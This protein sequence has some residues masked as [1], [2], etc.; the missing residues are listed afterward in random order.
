MGLINHLWQSTVFGL[1]AGVLTLALRKNRAQVRYGLWL[2][3]SVKFLI[4]F[5][6]LMSLGSLAPRPAVVTRIAPPAVAVAI[7]QLAEPLPET[8]SPVA[9]RS[10]VPWI[11]IAWACG[12]ADVVM[13]RLRGWARVRTAVRAS[14]PVKLSAAVEVRSAPGLLEPGVVGVFQP[15]LL[16]PK[17]IAEKLTLAQFEA[18]LTHELGHVRRRDNLTS[19]IHMLVRDPNAPGPRQP[20]EPTGRPSIFTA[21]QEQLGL[22][23]ESGKGSREVLV[24]DHVERPSEN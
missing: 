9:P 7:V 15:I 5:A 22:K 17:G 24:I 11:A 10:Q 13:M 4:P 20:S 12:F 21:L 1:A 14:T 6:F 2:A 18:V 19:A 3:A 8:S 23:L 16:L